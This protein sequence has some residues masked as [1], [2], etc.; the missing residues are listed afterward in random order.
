M[1]QSIA[2][3]FVTILGIPALLAAFSTPALCQDVEIGGFAKTGTYV[4][5]SNVFDFALDGLTFD[6]QS[7]YQEIGGD[8]ILILPKL[9]RKSA[10]RALVG[11]RSRW[12]AFEV[13]YDR[14][15]HQGRFLD[16]TGEAIFHS[17][18]GDER[19]FVLTRNR[20]QPYG[21]LGFSY[22]WLTIKDGSFLDPNI[23]DATF[24]GMGV[25]MEGGVMVYPIPRVGISTGYRYHAMWFDRA[26]GVSDREYELRPRFRETTGSV[27]VTAL[28][29]F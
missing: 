24:R 25:N 10:M 6:G 22:Q 11:F 17:I 2:G 15:K 21:L 8:E 23:G 27:V 7:Y 18:N 9:D 1:P 3:R 14:T 26:I 19:I 28:F 4:G 12:G 29:T 5:V 16:S 13:S 20:I